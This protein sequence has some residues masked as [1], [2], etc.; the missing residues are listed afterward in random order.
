MTLQSSLGSQAR[1][2]AFG[3]RARIAHTPLPHTVA[4]ACSQASLPAVALSDEKRLALHGSQAAWRRW[5]GQG[6]QLGGG[7]GR[8][9]E[10]RR[11]RARARVLGGR[12]VVGGSGVGVCGGRVGGRSAGG[13][14]G[15]VFLAW[16]SAGWLCGGALWGC[17]GLPIL[18]ESS[19]CF[20]SFPLPFSQKL[21]AYSSPLPTPPAQPHPDFHHLPPLPPPP[22]QPPTHTTPHAPTPPITCH[23]AHT[24]PIHRPLRPCARPSGTRCRTDF[25]WKGGPSTG[26]KGSGAKG[27]GKGKTFIEESLSYLR[28]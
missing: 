12:A 3:H 9:R 14:R 23:I 26:V 10:Q 4:S 27:T 28:R 22:T 7:R 5:K 13:G 18:C 8:G 19:L 1:G 2:I 15:G 17:L 16:G 21:I 24:P 25:G 11:A 6:K 20:L